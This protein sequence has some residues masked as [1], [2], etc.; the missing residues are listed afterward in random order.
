MKRAITAFCTVGVLLAGCMTHGGSSLPPMT[1]ARRETESSPLLYVSDPL[2]NKIDVYHATGTNQQPIATITKG[3]DGPGGL[4]ADAAGDLYVANTLNDTV[5]EYA[6]NGSAPVK[7]YS[8]DLNGPMDV[9]IDGKGT[10]YVANFYSFRDSIV[11]FPAGSMNPSITIKN[12]CSCTPAGL[13]LDASDNLYVTY[14]TT[15]VL[16]DVW[17]YAP[18][19]R[20]ATQRILGWHTS[21]GGSKTFFAPGL[22]FDKKGNLL[23]TGPPLPGI[24]VFSPGS[25]SPSSIFDKQGTPQFVQFASTAQSDVFV[26]DT[27]HNAVEEYTYPSGKLVDTIKSGLKSVY[28]LTVSP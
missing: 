15:Y 6:P 12:S 4:A 14:Q 21:S 13:T 10:L 1:S 17:W 26:T 28:G 19:S 25:Q 9:A 7:T 2:A 18:G 23:V 16:A 11:E 5:T 8:E 22:L 3:I 20:K 27:A 24:L